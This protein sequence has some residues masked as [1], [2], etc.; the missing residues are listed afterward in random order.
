MLDLHQVVMAASAL[1]FWPPH[2][3]KANHKQ[4]LYKLLGKLHIREDVWLS[5]GLARVVLQYF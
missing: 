5:V 2:G 3:G 4:L 1:S